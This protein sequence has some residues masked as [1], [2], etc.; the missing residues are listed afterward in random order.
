[1]SKTSI[2]FAFI[3]SFIIYIF[4]WNN[5]L[6]TPLRIFLTAIHESFHGLATI[7]TGGSIYKMSLNHF[8][9]VLTSMGGF[10]PFISISGYL[11]STLLGALLI[12]SKH[13]SLYLILISLIVFFISLIYIDKYFSVE[14]LLLNVM[15]VTLFIFIYKAK[16]L[17]EISL[18]LG[19]MLGVESIQDIQMYLFVAP[20]KTDSGLLA[21]YIGLSF[22]TLPISIF[23][24]I[25]SILIWYKIGLK[26]VVNE[27]S[28]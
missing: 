1:M 8:S 19:T 24:F 10:Y 20:E 23:M 26:R 22:L 2:L 15:I 21:N 25:V 17:N 5:I 12:S 11:G 14:F 28:L 6:I 16:F 7:L 27:K 18:F 4:F 13:K 3:I 9:G